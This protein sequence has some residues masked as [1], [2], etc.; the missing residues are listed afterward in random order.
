MPSGFR[1]S[2]VSAFA[3]PLLLGVIAARPAAAVT[4]PSETSPDKLAA[5]VTK[6]SLSFRWISDGPFPK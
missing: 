1:I 3:V 4:C 6:R 2:G 5:I